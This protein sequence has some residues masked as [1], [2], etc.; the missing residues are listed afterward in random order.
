MLHVKVA[1]WYL[2]SLAIIEYCVSVFY[3]LTDKNIWWFVLLSEAHLHLPCLLY[4]MVKL[5]DP[6]V[7]FFENVLLFN[8]YITNKLQPP[9]I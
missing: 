1:I 2:S 4:S 5:E 7:Y 8:S 9:R 6:E 3:L